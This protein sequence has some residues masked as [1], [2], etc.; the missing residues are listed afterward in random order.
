M[1]QIV[2]GEYECQIFFDAMFSFLKYQLRAD[3]A[4]FTPSAP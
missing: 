3:G 2:K 1:Q 4:T